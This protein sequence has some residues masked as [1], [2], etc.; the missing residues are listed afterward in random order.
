MAVKTLPLVAI[1]L[2]LACAA[3]GDQPLAD[4]GAH[5]GKADLA[6]DARQWQPI[7]SADAPDTVDVG[8]WNLYW[9]GDPEHGPSDDDLQ[10]ENAADVLGSLEL[11]VVGLSEV[12]SEEAFDEL[13]QQLPGYQGLLVTDAIVS[14]GADFYWDGEQKVALVHRER[15]E[16]E[17][18]R[19][20]LEDHNWDFAGRPPLEVTLRFEEDGKPRTLVVIVA[21]FKALANSYGYERR[22]AAA[23]ALEDYLEEAYR[24]RWVLVIGDFN[25]D[26][27]ESTFGGHESPFSTLVESPYYRFTTDMLSEA[28]ESTTTHYSS[29]IDHHL[30]TDDLEERF[31]EGSAAVLRID[32]H[33]PGYADTTS[34]HF[35]VLT[36]YDL[37]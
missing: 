23:T 11:D 13:M 24:Y 8:S 26:I 35:P 14:G 6:S 34:D 22:I 27:Y 4:E 37:R 20:I 1:S 17:S 25:D 19:V 31:V 18:A 9:F 3:P 15:F 28:G 21:H 12:V 30:A 5:Q 10:I 36:R 33:I 7:P 29:T 16:V 2:S 32:E